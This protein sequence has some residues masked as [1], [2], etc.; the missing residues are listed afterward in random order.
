MW[1]VSI[2]IQTDST[3]PK[4][5]ERCYGYLIECVTQEG[6]LHRKEE[7][8]EIEGTFHQTTL[9]AIN[10]AMKRLNQSCTVHIYTEDGFICNMFASN[11]DKWAVNDWKTSKNSEVENREEWEEFWKLTRGQLV[12]MIPGEHQYSDWLIAKMKAEKQEIS[13]ERKTGEI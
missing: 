2:Y 4:E 5:L 6:K 13:Q 7:T 10:K 9:T 3:C 8:G 12:R 1:E 11:I